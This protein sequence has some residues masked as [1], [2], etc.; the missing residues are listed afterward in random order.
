MAL[1]VHFSGFFY[2]GLIFLVYVIFSFN[3]I[4]FQSK[5]GVPFHKY[6][7]IRWLYSRILYTY[8]KLINIFQ[9]PNIFIVPC[10]CTQSHQTDPMH[11]TTYSPSCTV[12]WTLQHH[13]YKN[14][15]NN[16]NE[17][18]KSDLKFKFLS[19]GQVYNANMRTL[20]QLKHW[21]A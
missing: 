16:R 14:N 8:T 19:Y 15:Y 3:I 6:R 9:G 20:M 1:K 18:I 17:K 7:P 13:M 2:Q 10:T 11:C 12:A 4:L 21:S 5:Y